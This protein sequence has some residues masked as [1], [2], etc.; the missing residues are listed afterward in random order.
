QKATWRG[1][2]RSVLGATCQT[3]I[4]LTRLYPMA[5]PEAKSRHGRAGGKG[6]SGDADARRDPPYCSCFPAVHGRHGSRAR[7]S[8]RVASRA[9]R[10]PQ[11]DNGLADFGGGREDFA[12]GTL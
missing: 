6:R 10:V 5:I 2:P 1:R 7:M 9:E 8:N 4:C 11:E 12:G 3:K